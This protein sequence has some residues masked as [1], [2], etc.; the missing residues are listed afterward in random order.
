ME[1]IE[2]ENEEDSMTHN[3]HHNRNKRNLL[4]I[5]KNDKLADSSQGCG[6]GNIKDYL[7]LPINMA[8]DDH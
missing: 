7:H 5:H 2:S 6:G 1:I 4:T 3:H 8:G